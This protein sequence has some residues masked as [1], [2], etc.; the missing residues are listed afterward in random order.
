MLPQGASAWPHPT[1]PGAAQDGG[2][3]SALSGIGAVRQTVCHRP[4]ALL[5]TLAGSGLARPC[6][7]SKAIRG[8][9]EDC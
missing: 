4:P 5:G 7:I 3:W 1:S 9:K 6:P 8:P 2:R